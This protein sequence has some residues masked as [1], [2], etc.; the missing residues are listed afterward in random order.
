MNLRMF[1]RVMIAAA[2]LAALPLTSSAQ[3]ARQNSNLGLKLNIGLGNQRLTSGQNLEKGDAAAV[4]LG[5]GVSQNVTLWLGLQGSAHK[6]SDNASLES[7]VGGLELNLQYKLRPYEKFRPYGKVGL[8][9]FVR[10]TEA[11]QTTLTGG[12]IVWAVG[13]DYRLLR[14]LS[15]G[16][17]FFWKDFDYERRRVGKNNEFTDLENPIRGNSNGFMLNLIIH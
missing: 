2:M 14:F 1:L 9:G 17:E 6:H 3:P 7:N 4:H 15:I 12:G 5:Y 10:E 11:T 8:G 16:G 13:A